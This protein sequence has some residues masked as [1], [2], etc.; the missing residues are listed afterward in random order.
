MSLDPTRVESIFSEACDKAS[1]EERAAFLAEACAGDSELRRRIE[2]LL[3]AHDRAGGFLERPA[4]QEVLAGAPVVF[5]EAGAT[6]LERR[7]P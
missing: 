2:A 7:S 3:E 4:I 5:C 6:A 1:A